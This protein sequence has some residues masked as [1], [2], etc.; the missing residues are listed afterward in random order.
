MHASVRRDR[1]P[2]LLSRREMPA[3]LGQ[4]LQDWQPLCLCRADRCRATV[5]GPTSVALLC[6]A[7]WPRAPACLLGGADL[8]PPAATTP[9]HQCEDLSCGRDA[10]FTCL[11]NSKGCTACADGTARSGNQCKPGAVLGSGWERL[12]QAVESRRPAAPERQPP[13]TLPLPAPSQC[14]V[15]GCADCSGNISKCRECYSWMGLV[16]NKCKEVSGH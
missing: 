6:A 13:Q 9:M 10:N 7:A 15:S 11:I 12:C 16:G 2:S 5:C 8:R 3:V 14:K 1:L 4:P